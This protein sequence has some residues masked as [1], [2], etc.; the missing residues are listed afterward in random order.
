M[1]LAIYILWE[2]DAV[3]MKCVCNLACNKV[4]ASV[5]LQRKALSIG[6]QGEGGNL[7]SLHPG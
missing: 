5:Y 2:T 1:P 7:H 3:E 6:G 4:D